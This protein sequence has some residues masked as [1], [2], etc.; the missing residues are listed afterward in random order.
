MACSCHSRQS[1][2]AAASVAQ[3]F[4]LDDDFAEKRST[5]ENV[6]H[7]PREEVDEKSNKN[8][9][10]VEVPEDNENISA[11]TNEGSRL[12]SNI[13]NHA[14]KSQKKKLNVPFA[15]YTLKFL[16]VVPQHYASI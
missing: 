14:K 9:V 10:A 13:W 4:S 12:K 6:T 2:G 15:K 7:I 1:R 5:N 3:N 16:V 8:N 11:D